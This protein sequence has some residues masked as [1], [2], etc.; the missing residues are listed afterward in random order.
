[1]NGKQIIESVEKLSTEDRAN[2]INMG[3]HVYSDSMR[4]WLVNISDLLRNEAISSDFS[5]SEGVA[6]FNEYCRKVLRVS[7]P[8]WTEERINKEINYFNG[9]SALNYEHIEWELLIIN[10]HYN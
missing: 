2:V 1:M 9:R 4:Y 8:Y 6:K 7:F 3:K 5:T 10:K